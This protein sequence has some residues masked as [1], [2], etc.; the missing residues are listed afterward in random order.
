MIEPIGSES[1]FAKH[2]KE[3]G[4]GLFHIAIFIEDWDE[5][6]RELKEKGFTVEVQ[7]AKAPGVSGTLKL[8]W[9]QPK[10]TR[11]VWIE[12]INI[13]TPPL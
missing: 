4:E 1:R 10:D 11:G 2:L 8:G 6:I 7:E 3:R 5:K 13:D 12:L 9:L